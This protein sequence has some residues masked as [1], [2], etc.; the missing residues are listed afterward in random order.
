MELLKN[1][2]KV[3]PSD[4]LFLH[5]Q[6]RLQ[7]L[8]SNRIAMHKVYAVAA[9]IFLLLTMNIMVITRTDIEHNTSILSIKTINNFYD[10]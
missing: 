3:A 9:S 5:I 7:E 2:T 6:D 8:N 1:I 10:E 4:Y